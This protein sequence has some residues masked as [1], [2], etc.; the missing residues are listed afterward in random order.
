MDAQDTRSLPDNAYEPLEEGRVYKPLV[1]PEKNL[2]QAT[3]RSVG[4]GLFF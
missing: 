4:W 1:P 2:P 3:P